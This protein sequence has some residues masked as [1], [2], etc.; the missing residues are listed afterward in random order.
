[1]PVTPIA[2][3]LSAA[4]LCAVQ[5]TALKLAAATPALL[6]ATLMLL[7]WPAVIAA[8]GVAALAAALLAPLGGAP[9]PIESGRDG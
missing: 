5:A 8:A 3:S 1:M 4:P 7:P 9:D 6:L 2:T